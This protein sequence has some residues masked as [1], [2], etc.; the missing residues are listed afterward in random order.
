[1]LTKR[2]ILNRNFYTSGGEFKIKQVSIG[3]D[4]TQNKTIV[5]IVIYGAHDFSKN[6]EFTLYRN[7]DDGEY[8][9]ETFKVETCTISGDETTLSFV[10][11]NFNTY[12]LRPS[13]IRKQTYCIDENIEL[14]GTEFVFD[15][16]KHIC[17]KDRGKIDIKNELSCGDSLLDANCNG[18][19][20]YDSRALYTQ[21]IIKGTNERVF[22]LSN[23]NSIYDSGSTHVL[24]YEGEAYKI[25]VPYSYSGYDNRTFMFVLDKE[26]VDGEEEQDS[27]DLNR[28]FTI[29]DCRFFDFNESNDEWFAHPNVTVREKKTSLNLQLPLSFDFNTNL[30]HDQLLEDYINDIKDNYVTKPLDYEKTMFTPVYYDNSNSIDLNSIRFNIFLRKRRFYEETMEWKLDVRPYGDSN[31]T[32]PEDS[33]YWNSYTYSGCTSDTGCTLYSG[34]TANTGDLLGDLGFDDND[35]LNQNKRLSKTFIRLL[36]FDKKDRNSQTLL[37]Y[38]TI[39]INTSDLHSKYI[40]NITNNVKFNNNNVTEYVDNAIKEE[41]LREQL[42][43][44]CNFTCFNK[45]NMNGSSEGYYLYLFPSLVNDPNLEDETNTG[46]TDNGKQIYMRVEFN[47]AKYGKTIPLIWRENSAPRNNYTDIDIKEGRTNISTNLAELYDDMYI[48]I[49]IKYDSNRKSYVWFFS[50][51]NEEDKNNPIFNMWEPKVR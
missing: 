3:H 22:T 43:L 51:V 48:P 18:Y 46:T 14:E 29:T 32:I 12:Y 6:G 38:S 7:L 37:Y 33:V 11:E 9:S 44:S 30:Y 31:E 16:F 5:S 10:Y 36:F 17:I 25:F 26:T 20:L 15:I 23:I 4:E 21:N 50:N 35:V 47:H 28:N 49:T 34:C 2:T 39:F 27:F 24:M 19:I 1:M 42:Q 13:Y 41:S 40:R 45:Y 8:F